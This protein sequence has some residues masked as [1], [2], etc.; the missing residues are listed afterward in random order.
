L[1]Q[2]EGYLHDSACVELVKEYRLKRQQLKDLK[3]QRAELERRSKMLAE[4][5]EVSKRALSQ[6]IKDTE[7]LGKKLAKKPVKIRMSLA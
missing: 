3:S 1:A 2:R 4:K 6:F 5:T 7:L